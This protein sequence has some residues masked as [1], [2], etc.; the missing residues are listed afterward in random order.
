[1]EKELTTSREMSLIS[2]PS[3]A[4]VVSVAGTLTVSFIVNGLNPGVSIVCIV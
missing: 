2:F 3:L 4:C 1:M